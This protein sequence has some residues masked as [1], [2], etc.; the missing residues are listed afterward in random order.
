[1]LWSQGNN[2]ATR[3]NVQALAE[4]LRANV[5]NLGSGS[6][7]PERPLP[8]LHSSRLDP[9]PTSPQDAEQLLTKNP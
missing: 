1:M 3:R 2:Q 5:D 8:V 7:A 6:R 9:P 4:R